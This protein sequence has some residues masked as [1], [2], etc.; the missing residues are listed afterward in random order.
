[1]NFLEV[2]FSIRGQTI[3]ADHGYALY[4]AV[5]KLLQEQKN[6]PIHQMSYLLS[7]FYSKLR[8][9]KPQL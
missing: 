8:P 7:C 6:S 9:F 3:P 4:S 2:Q 5:K 1:M